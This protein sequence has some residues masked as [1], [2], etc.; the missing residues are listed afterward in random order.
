MGSSC[1]DGALSQG[2]LWKPSS[3]LG[4]LTLSKTPPILAL[5]SSSFFI[6]FSFSGDYLGQLVSAGLAGVLVYLV[7]SP[8]Q[9]PCAAA[10]VWWF[11]LTTGSPVFW[12]P[13]KQTTAM[14]FGSFNIYRSFWI[15]S[16]FLIPFPSALRSTLSLC[17]TLWVCRIAQVEG[18]SGY[19]SMADSCQC[20]AKTPTIL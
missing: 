16:W 17:E 19:K 15:L 6:H 12:W 5:V 13:L 3:A 1:V 2:T 4:P 9:S 7:A 11:P 8:G 20:M 14:S 18:G 10:S